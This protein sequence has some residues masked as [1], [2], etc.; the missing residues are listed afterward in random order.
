VE[1]DD[2]LGIPEAQA[3]LEVV[4]HFNM[5]MGIIETNMRNLVQMM[6]Q[7]SLDTEKQQKQCWQ[8]ED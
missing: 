1:D 5:D 4:H 3:A 7:M 2:N 8:L 6:E